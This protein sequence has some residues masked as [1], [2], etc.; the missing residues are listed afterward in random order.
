[1]DGINQKVFRK[2]M[3]KSLKSTVVYRPMY[4][5]ISKQIQLRKNKL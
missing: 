5:V 4:R 3:E 1:M 2:N